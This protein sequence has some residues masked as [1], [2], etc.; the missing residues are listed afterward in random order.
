MVNSFPKQKSL[1]LPSTEKKKR[2]DHTKSKYQTRWRSEAIEI[3]KINV[4]IILFCVL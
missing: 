2:S 1:K 3:K 4:L